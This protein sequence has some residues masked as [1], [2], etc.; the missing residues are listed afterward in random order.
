MDFFFGISSFKKG[1]WR[2]CPQRL[3]SP[4]NTNGISLFRWL[5]AV[6]HL[7]SPISLGFSEIFTIECTNY[8]ISRLS[9]SVIIQ[10]KCKN[11]F[12]TL[13]A[14][15][16]LAGLC[17]AGIRG[18]VLEVGSRTCSWS[19]CRSQHSVRGLFFSLREKKKPPD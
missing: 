5:H 17:R 11:P 6:L 7:E 13:K 4:L 10:S 9:Q 15:E 18:F 14:C 3:V 2:H 8:D 12:S 16:P 1:C 19:G